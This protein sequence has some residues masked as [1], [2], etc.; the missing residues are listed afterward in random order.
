[1]CRTAVL[2]AKQPEHNLRKRQ[3]SNLQDAFQ[4]SSDF[5]SGE[6]TNAQHFQVQV[7]QELYKMST[8]RN[9]LRRKRIRT[10]ISKDHI[11]RATTYTIQLS[12]LNVRCGRG[13]EPPSS[14]PQ[15]EVLTVIRPVHC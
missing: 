5:K 12:F 1:M 4:R 8:L 13:V 2:A 10:P 7:V 14:D 6:L 3:E 15:S 11:W 9:Y